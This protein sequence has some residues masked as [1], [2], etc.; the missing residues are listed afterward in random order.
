MHAD[1]VKIQTPETTALLKSKFQDHANGANRRL[2]GI[3]VEEQLKWQMHIKNIGRTVYTNIFH[4]SKVSQ[5][6]SHKAKLASFSAHI[7]SHINYVSNACDE[8]AWCAHEAAA[9]SPQTYHK[10]RNGNS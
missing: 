5:I 8:C 2:R 7:M 1:D 3:T 10:I 4:L 6:V 9:L